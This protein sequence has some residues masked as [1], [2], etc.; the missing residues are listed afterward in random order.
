[1]RPLALKWNPHHQAVTCSYASSQ[2]QYNYTLSSGKDEKEF[3]SCSTDHLSESIV[4]NSSESAL[5]L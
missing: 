1:M 3:S 4:K 2:V 5:I